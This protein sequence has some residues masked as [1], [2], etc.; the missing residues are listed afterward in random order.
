MMAVLL[1]VAQGLE[2]PTVSRHTCC[3]PQTMRVLRIHKASSHRCPRRGAAPMRLPSGP[4]FRKL[5]WE[6]IE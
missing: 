3:K 4:A 1:L 2:K 6:S 5:L